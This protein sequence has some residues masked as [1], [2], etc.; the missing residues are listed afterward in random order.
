MASPAVHVLAVIAAASALNPSTGL[1]RG[2]LGSQAMSPTISTST[3]TPQ[4]ED[5]RDVV[6]VC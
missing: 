6:T 4:K 5:S 1:T 3:V 2:R